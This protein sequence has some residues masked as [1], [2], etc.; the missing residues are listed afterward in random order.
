MVRHFRNQRYDAPFVTFGPLIF[1]VISFTFILI[2]L[3]LDLDILDMMKISDRHFIEELLEL[4][5]ALALFY[6]AISIYQRVVVEEK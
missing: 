6:G 3:V 4:F 2:S 5:A 1:T